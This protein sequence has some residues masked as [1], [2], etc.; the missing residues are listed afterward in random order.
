MKTLIGKQESTSKEI[1]LKDDD[2]D[3]LETMLQFPYDDDVT[4][5]FA[6]VKELTTIEKLHYCVGLYALADKYDIPRLRRIIAFRFYREICTYVEEHAQ[7]ASDPDFIDIVKR[8][9]ELEGPPEYIEGESTFEKRWR[10]VYRLRDALIMCFLSVPTANPNISVNLT[11]LFRACIAAVPELGQDILLEAATMFS[12]RQ[13]RTGNLAKCQSC[14]F[15][16]EC[17]YNLQAFRRCPAC[18][19]H[20]AKERKADRERN[21]DE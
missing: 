18:G 14:D 13:L 15:R 11:P 20:G 8:V 19:L 6:A 9:V 17:A 4:K 3:L 10:P 16:W 7:L 21:E 2:P 5:T 12:D 1:V